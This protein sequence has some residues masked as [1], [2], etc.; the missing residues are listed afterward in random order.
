MPSFNRG[1][2]LA[3]QQAFDGNVSK[4]PLS[5]TWMAGCIRK[6][7][8]CGSVCTVRSCR[9]G[10][11]TSSRSFPQQVL[12]L[13]HFSSGTVEAKKSQILYSKS[14]EYLRFLEPNGAKAAVG[15]SEF[16]SEEL[17]EVVFVEAM[18]SAEEG[19]EVRVNKGDP[20]CTLEALKSV[21]EVYAPASGRIV[22]F[23]P[24]VQEEP[25]LINKDPEGEGWLFI[26]E[27]DEPQG[28]VGGLPEECPQAAARSSLLTPEEYAAHVMKESE[29]AGGC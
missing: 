17:G 3:A 2:R 27:L 5:G 6:H 16:A 8:L 10:V 15:V 28:D 22:H 26:M 20:V 25:G 1:L 24:Q 18:V 9:Y 11:L 4:R 23:N 19:T 12:D 29:A 14:H 7:Q 21:A 13:R